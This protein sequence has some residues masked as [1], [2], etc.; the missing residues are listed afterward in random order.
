MGGVTSPLGKIVLDRIKGVGARA[1]ASVIGASQ[2]DHCL[3]SIRQCRPRPC[4]K[5][6]AV[7]Q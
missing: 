2:N 7:G 4:S 5:L 3:C 1:E 6:E